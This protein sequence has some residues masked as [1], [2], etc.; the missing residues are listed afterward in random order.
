MVH[1][2]LVPKAFQRLDEFRGKYS[3]KRLADGFGAAEGVHGLHLRVPAFDASVEIEGQN[4][5]IDGLDDVF[6]ELLE[7]LEFVD[8][9]LETGVEDGVLEGNADVAG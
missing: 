3:T 4:A 8:L 7:A 6:V 1:A 9:F 5:H 2:G